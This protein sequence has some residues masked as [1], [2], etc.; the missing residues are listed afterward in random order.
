M[1]VQKLRS[2]SDLYEQKIRDGGGAASESS[3]FC[4]SCRP[5]GRLAEY[6]LQTN[7]PGNPITRIPFAHTPPKQSLRSKKSCHLRIPKKKT[8]PNR[9]AILGYTV[10]RIF[11]NFDDS[12][13]SFS[14]VRYMFRRFAST[15]SCIMQMRE[16]RW[17]VA[18]G[19]WFGRQIGTH[20]YMYTNVL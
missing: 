10:R 16:L 18:G 6:R 5:S 17:K 3:I 8:L 12:E 20:I 7:L 14:L 11:W 15:I 13:S 1:K 2:A 9:P 4:F 19:G